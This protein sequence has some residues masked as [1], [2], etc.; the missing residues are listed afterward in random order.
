M[1]R[2]GSVTDGGYDTAHG[3][4]ANSWNPFL[5]NGDWPEYNLADNETANGDISGSSSQYIHGDLVHF[6]AGIYQVVSG[7]TPGVSYEFSVGWAAMLR[8]TG[9]GNNTKKDNVVIRKV[10]VDPY[11]GV[12]PNSPNMQWG[13]NWG[14]ARRDGV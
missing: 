14:Q 12:D 6:D 10:G 7:T 2:N 1:T 5:I 3:V 13:P 8:D 4:V 11:G 9:G